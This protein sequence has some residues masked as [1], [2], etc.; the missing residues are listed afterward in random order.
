MYGWETL[1]NGFAEMMR[2]YDMGLMPS[3]DVVV[4]VDGVLVKM[5]RKL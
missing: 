2:R 1:V 4:E 5:G 3:I